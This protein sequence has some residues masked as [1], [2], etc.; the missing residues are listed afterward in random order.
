MPLVRLPALGP[1]GSFPP[2]HP[3]SRRGRRVRGARGSP[4]RAWPQKPASP[5]A[6][7][8]SGTQP[9]S[10]GQ[11]PAS[12]RAQG[13]SHP[14]GGLCLPPHWANGPCK[15]LTKPRGH[16]PRRFLCAAGTGAR[17]PEACR[18]RG[19]FCHMGPGAESPL[20]PSYHS[21]PT[22]RAQYLTNSKFSKILDE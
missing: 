21:I 10:A 20:S 18:S 6:V 8:L 9:A 12:R 19:T 16:S 2:R 13:A 22:R 11:R 15:A 17:V 3:A 1:R 14:G 4:S 7:P 5:S